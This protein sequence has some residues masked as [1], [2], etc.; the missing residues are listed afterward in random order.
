MNSL[1]QSLKFPPLRICRAAETQNNRE[2]E[3]RNNREAETQNNREM[4]IRNNPE[5]EIPPVSGP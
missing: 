1:Q 3:I 4:E 2:A 5:V